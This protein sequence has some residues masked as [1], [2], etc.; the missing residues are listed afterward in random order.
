MKDY[1]VQ[2]VMIECPL[3][4]QVHDVEERAR[5]AKA[6]IKG[7]SIEYEERYFICSNVDEDENEF[8]PS[9][10]MDLNLLQ[11]RNAYRTMK[12]LLTSQ[13]IVAIREKVGLSQVELANLLGWGEVT[14]SRYES[15]AIQ[16]DTYDRILRMVD[17]N[18]ME[19]LNFLNKN[20]SLF[21]ILRYRDIKEKIIRNLD[22]YGKGYL[23]RQE[24]E[25]EYVKYQEPSDLNGYQSLNI[26][27][28]G[29]VVSFF[30]INLH[31][32]YKVKLMKLLWYADALSFKRHGK[33]ITGL[34]YSHMPLGALPIG[35]YKLL[36]LDNIC[37]SEEYDDEGYSRFHILPCQNADWTILS[38]QDRTILSEVCTKFKYMNGQEFA[39]YMHQEAAYQLTQER[40]EIPFSLT[41]QLKEF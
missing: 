27:K 21:S 25:S 40:Q 26:D 24:F 15:K 36:G 38:E 28:I 12:G 35:H 16:D 3:C 20:R 14:I 31:S 4:D 30:A 41:M 1:L 17:C 19:M 13:Q 8:I 11:A 22:E 7:E 34:V 37:V 2:R 32:L 5:L 6:Q 18:P 10:V 9:K 39:D 29:G 33:S 23:K